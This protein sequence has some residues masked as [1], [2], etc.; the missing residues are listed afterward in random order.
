MKAFVLKYKWLIVIIVILIIVFGGRVIQ[1]SQVPAAAGLHEQS[2]L[3]REVT[4]EQK[5]KI[6]ELPGTIEAY[7]T[8]VVSP[9]YG[10]KVKQVLV[11]NGDHVNGGQTL[12]IFDSVQQANALQKAKSA[13]AKTQSNLSNSQKTYD[14]LRQLLEAG[15]VS[16]SDWIMPGWPWTQPNDADTALA[17]CPMRRTPIMTRGLIPQSAEW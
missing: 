10:G 4:K 3:V 5:E 1:K 2:V 17:A 11:E 6:L 13:V 12:L 16:Q 15:A 9:K 14:Q 8:L 7:A